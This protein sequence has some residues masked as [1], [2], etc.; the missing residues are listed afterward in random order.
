MIR[1]VADRPLLFPESLKQ[2]KILSGYNECITTRNESVYASGSD[3]LDYCLANVKQNDELEPCDSPASISHLNTVCYNYIE[4]Y[5]TFHHSTGDV[6]YH[7]CRLWP[8]NQLLISLIGVLNVVIDSNIM[9]QIY[10]SHDLACKMPCLCIFNV[11]RHH[12]LQ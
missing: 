9:I 12:K 3:V 7:P 8:N 6:I 2:P 1:K 4:L 10:P 5:M 11:W